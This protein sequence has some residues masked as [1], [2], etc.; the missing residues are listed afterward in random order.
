MKAKNMIAEKIPTLPLYSE[1]SV[2]ITF[3]SSVEP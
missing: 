3:P 1:I 2:P